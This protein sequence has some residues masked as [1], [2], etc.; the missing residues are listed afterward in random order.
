MI[1]IKIVFVLFLCLILIHG[2]QAQT[3]R[4]A[5]CRMD[6]NNDAF[7]AKATSESGK[8][9][10]FDAIECLVN[11]LKSEEGSNYKALTV[12][13]YQTLK[14]IDATKAFYI[15]SKAIP[16]PMGAN[17]AA[18]STESAALSVR[19]DKGGEVLRWKEIKERF[20]TSK[21]GASEHLFHHHNRPDAYA[22]AGMMGDHLHP[23]GGFMLTLRSMHMLMHGNRDGSVEI[24][25]EMIYDEFMV[26]PQDM[27]MQMY[28]LG[29]MYAP[30]NKVTLMLMQNFVRKEMD[31]TA[32]MMGG[33]I[34]VFR[35]FSTSSGG[36]GDLKLSMLYGLY[37]QEKSSL[38]LNTGLS[39][40]VGNIGNRDAIPMIP[41]AKLPYAMQLGTGTFD[42]NI[43][44]TLKGKFDKASWGVQPLSTFRTGMNDEGYRFGNLYELHT[45]I[46]YLISNKLSSS[47]RLSGSIEDG[48][49]GSDPELNPMMVTTADAANYGGEVLLGTFGLNVLLAENKIVLGG[50]IG[51]PLY[52]NYRGIFMN[53]DLSVN[54]SIKYTLF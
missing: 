16:S 2:S 20:T 21:F 15:K 37:A 5:Y 14:T 39:I 4:C 26:A 49:K 29:V 18:F 35:N 1:P 8:A 30:S 48:I 3:D 44:V 25:D 27:M 46:G 51:T 47:F 43:G 23:R 6:I 52:Q 22:P 31:L 9:L 12:T 41:D 11:S 13:D 7:K 24:T 10:Q 53:Q 34:P 42:I 33:G 50:E 36:L 45:W 40:P 28:M 54:A 38:H 17:L 19:N 32:R